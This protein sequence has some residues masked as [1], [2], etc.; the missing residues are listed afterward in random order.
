MKTLETE[1]LVLRGWQ[2]NDIADL[3][4]IMKNPSVSNGG[5]KP[6]SDINTSAEI[7]N[8]YIKSDDVWAVELKCRKKV[9]GYIKISPDNNRGKHNAKSISYVLA[10]DYWGSGYMTEAVKRIVDYVF[11]DLNADLLSA[12]HY[13]DNNKSQ[14]VLEKCGFEYEITIKQGCKR[15]DGML[16]DSVCY[17]LLKTDYYKK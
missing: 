1:R 8:D 13:H 15:Y 17:S 6:H 9:I 14:R 10:E 12:F 5:W 11:T 3:F 7:L 2:K 16:F 4:D